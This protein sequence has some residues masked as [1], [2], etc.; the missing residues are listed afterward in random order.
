VY[1]HNGDALDAFSV[2]GKLKWEISF[3]QGV[4]Q[5]VLSSPTIAADGTI[6]VAIASGQL[7]AISP[8]GTIIKAF[9]F[10]GNSSTPAITADGAL[11]FMNVTESYFKPHARGY[12][13]DLSPG[14]DVG[15]FDYA[16]SDQAY[17]SLGSDGSMYLRLDHAIIALDTTGKQLWKQMSGSFNS[18]PAVAKDGTLY[19]LYTGNSFVTA[20]HPDGTVKWSFS[21][22]QSEGAFVRTLG[23]AADGTIYVIGDHFYILDT[24][25]KLV[26]TVDDIGNVTVSSELAIDDDGTAIFGTGDGTL[27]AR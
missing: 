2:A 26:H 27:Y 20:L 23:V 3:K 9:D 21:G 5:G 1:V 13:P 17:P 24:D 25:G 8:H 10:K 11:R 7:T 22:S 14:F 18:G 6:Y 12:A 4:E 19:S 15:L 16:S